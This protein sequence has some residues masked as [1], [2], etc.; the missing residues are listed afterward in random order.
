MQFDNAPPWQAVATG[1][2]MP[3]GVSGLEFYV[4][5]PAMKQFGNE[6]RYSNQVA[7]S[8]PDGDEKPWTGK[9]TGSGAAYTAFTNCIQRMIQ[10]TAPNTADNGGPQP[11]AKS[12]PSQ[13]FRAPEPVAPTAP[14]ADRY[15]YEEL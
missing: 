13:P 8:F 15:R 10:S 7:I 12:K 3:N 6:M 2:S 4:P 11:F 9:L 5:E 14:V 1:F